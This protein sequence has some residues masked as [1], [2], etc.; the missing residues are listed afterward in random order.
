MT[1]KRR[2]IGNAPVVA[3]PAHKGAPIHIEGFLHGFFGIF[4]GLLQA[5][6]ASTLH[7]RHRRR[8]RLTNH[9]LTVAATTR[10]LLRRPPCRPPRSIRLAFT[11]GQHTY[12][13]YS[14]VECGIS[15]TYT[16]VFSVFMSFFYQGSG[17]PAR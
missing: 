8:R 5:R 17:G 1:A 11:T 4:L 6:L 14:G 9:R 12:I 13:Q 7:R 10:R 16:H 15:F 2:S 3:P